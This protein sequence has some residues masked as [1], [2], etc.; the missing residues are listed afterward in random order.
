MTS[1]CEEYTPR[2]H[3]VKRRTAKEISEAAVLQWAILW[4]SGCKTFNIEKISDILGV[5][6]DICLRVEKNKDWEKKHTWLKKG[7]SIPNKRLILIPQRG[8]KGAIR[9]NYD[10]IKTFCHELG[11]VVLKHE[12]TYHRAENGILTKF[13]D[14]EVQAD[15][16]AEVMM[17]LFNI[18]PEK[19]Q[20]SLPF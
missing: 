12:P 4:D 10:D 7:E 1:Y 2:G 16:F 14:A 13:D 20:L 17:A 6:Q 18:E 3:I 19:I 8:Y 11:H 9:G 15:L 5:E